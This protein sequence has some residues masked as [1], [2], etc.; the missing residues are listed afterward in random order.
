MPTIAISYRREDTRWIVGRIFDHLVGYY[1]HDN[2]FMDIDGV[3]LGLDFRDQIRNTLQRS[4]ILLAVI[5]PQWLAAQK[6]TGQPRI[7]D[8]TDWVHIEIQAALGKNIPVIPVLIDRTP[9]PKPNELPEDLRAFAYRQAANIDTGVDF[10]SHM[11]RLIRAID[12]LLDG[13]SHTTKRNVELSSNQLDNNRAPFTL[14]GNTKAGLGQRR[15]LEDM[16]PAAPIIREMI[17][18]GYAWVNRQANIWLQVVKS[19]KDFVSSI[20]LASTEELGKSVQFL[21]FALAC[22]QILETPLEVLAVHLNAY[23][24]TTL[25]TNFCMTALEVII[26]GSAAWFF[27]RAMKG[28]GQYRSVSVA[29]FYAYTALIPVATIVKYLAG[30]YW[31]GSFVSDPDPSPLKLGYFLVLVLIFYGFVATKLIPVI[32]FIHL[33]GAIRATLVFCLS[34]TASALLYTIANPIFAELIKSAAPK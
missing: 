31:G 23:D 8:E 32:K 17:G 4:D 3:P 7:A 13:Q 11:D 5:G 27:G 22:N 21:F 19:P 16:S 6:D 18:N 14:L 25:I 29:I 10:Q 15:K 33:I 28:K 9:L 20:D 24:P 30:G 34:V 1:G 12:Q 2:I 26:C